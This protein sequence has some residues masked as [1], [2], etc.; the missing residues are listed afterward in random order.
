[1]KEFRSVFFNGYQKAEVDEYVSSLTE[2]LEA[3]KRKNT[4]S[5]LEKDR[6]IEELREKLRIQQEE[7]Q[8]AQVQ[9]KELEEEHQRLKGLEEEF[10]GSQERL[11]KYEAGY[12]DF[13]D[14]MAGMKAQAREMVQEASK[15][16]EEIISLAKK[17]ADEITTSA[18]TGARD[19]TDAARLNAESY[20]LNAEQEIER[21]RL[22]ED[23]R[24]NAARERLEAYL[25]S[26]KQAQYNLIDVYE[27]LG[28]VVRNM[29]MQLSDIYTDDQAVELLDCE[30]TAEE[31]EGP[32]VSEE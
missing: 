19:I 2:E 21:K 11:K 16:A 1:M 26:V 32:Q 28:R 10:S 9:K 30:D 4:G 23:A 29:P 27:Q 12:S 31:P 7:S 5:L 20:K 25:D 14:L 8:K 17:D 15:N 18:R 3:L 13:V 6:L 22:E 24:L